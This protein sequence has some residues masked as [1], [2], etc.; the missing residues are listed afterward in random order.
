MTMIMQSK[1]L[2]LFRISV[3]FNIKTSEFDSDLLDKKW[4]DSFNIDMDVIKSSYSMDERQDYIEKKLGF[5]LTEINKKDLL[6]RELFQLE[7][8]SKIL[9]YSLDDYFISWL[10]NGSAGFNKNTLVVIHRIDYKALVFPDVRV[11]VT[12]KFSFIMPSLNYS[13][14][15]SLGN[16]V[17]FDYSGIFNVLS[18][19]SFALPPPWGVFSAAGFQLIELIIG[20]FTNL[21]SFNSMIQIIR[22]QLE[23]EFKAHDVTTYAAE[24]SNYMTQF[25]TFVATANSL[26]N[27]SVYIENEVLPFL[28][29]QKSTTSG[30]IY[31]SLNQLLIKSYYLGTEPDDKLANYS[32]TLLVQ[33]LTAIIINQRTIIIFTAQLSSLQ[34]GVDESKYNEYLDLWLGEYVEL[35]TLINNLIKENNSTNDSFVKHRN[36]MMNIDFKPLPHRGGVTQDA[37]CVIQDSWTGYSSTTS[38]GASQTIDEFKNSMLSVYNSYRNEQSENF[39]VWIENI[40]PKDKINSKLADSLKTWN[41][42][43]SPAQPENTIEVEFIN[44][45]SNPRWSD[46]KTIYYAIEFKNF[47]GSSLSEYKEFTTIAGK[48]P[49]LTS[50]PVDNLYLTRSRILHYRD[51]QVKDKIIFVFKNNETTTYDDE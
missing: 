22:Q 50:I 48:T 32:S 2:F 1:A 9:G 34:R 47:L 44:E 6:R 49:S 7:W 36:S 17:N 46:K 10:R 16:N 43:T 11:L 14:Y 12:D 27:N 24:L 35:R 39:S 13:H 31:D 19:L 28:K 37:I 29:G 20:S 38:V 3:P 26:P 51:E 42:K 23:L 25:Q 41:E 18:T 15:K 30:S 45:S 5:K 40:F 8:Y 21:S 33:L 4:M